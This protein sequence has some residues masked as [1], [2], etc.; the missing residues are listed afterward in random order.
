MNKLIDKFK[1]SKNIAVV[2]AS[3]NKSKYGYKVY[4][5]LKRKNFNVFPV[6]PSKDKIDD[7]KVFDSILEIKEKIDSVSMIVNPKI[8][9]KVIKEIKKMGINLVWF[10]PGAYNSEILNYCKKNDIETIYERCVLVDL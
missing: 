2:G 5:K 4:K 9:K 3:D 8:G 10:Q 1:K 6:N 7:D